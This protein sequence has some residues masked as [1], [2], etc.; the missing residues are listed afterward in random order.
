[1]PI[2]TVS[3]SFSTIEK[4]SFQS[5]LNLYTHSKHHSIRTFIHP[6]VVLRFDVNLRPGFDRFDHIF[7]KSFSPSAMQVD[8]LYLH[9]AARNGDLITLTSAIASGTNLDVRDKHAR[10]PLMLAAW[11]NHINCVK[12]LAAGGAQI[13]LGAQDDV[14]PLLFAVQKGHAGIVTWLLDNGARVNNKNGRTGMTA[15]AIAAQQ[16]N[17]QLVDILLKHR[18][19]PTISMKGG[20]KPKELA[21]DASVVAL[22]TDA[23]AKWEEKKAKEAEK[24]KQKNAD[25]FAPPAVAVRVVDSNSGGDGGGDDSG[26]PAPR[27]VNDTTNEKQE[28]KIEGQEH[29]EHKNKKPR[30]TLNYDDADDDNA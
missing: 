12:I 25:R 21:T 22:L 27:V 4:H 13:N 17:E 24:R 15:L 19:D 8:P 23:E 30:V 18:A 1:M 2:K 14:T 29:E 26:A 11:A 16:N 7:S 9:N 5:F 6:T 10:T 20:K 3:L 28:E